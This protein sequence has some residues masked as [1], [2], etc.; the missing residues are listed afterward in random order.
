MLHRPPLDSFDT[1]P[2]RVDSADR[3]ETVK[4]YLRRK[5]AADVSGLKA[6]AEKIFTG[7]A[8]NA[9]T[10]NGQSFEGG[11]AQ[12]VITFEP[13][14]YLKAV[15]EVIAELDDDAPLET[16]NSAQLRFSVPAYAADQFRAAE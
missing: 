12:G 11:S 9:V 2:P 1:R 3:I 5:Y 8:T 15:E 14:A 4:R 13:L 7:G 10:I 16:P 6:L